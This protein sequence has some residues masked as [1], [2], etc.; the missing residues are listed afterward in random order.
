[1]PEVDEKIAAGLMML[2]YELE[3]V[4]VMDKIAPA[5]EELRGKVKPA[6]VILAM[7]QLAT[8]FIESNKGRDVAD[9]FAEQL[10]QALMTAVKA[11]LPETK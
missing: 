5:V 2:M 6:A 11:N 9:K 10:A 7:F 3:M 8:E 1:M 4:M